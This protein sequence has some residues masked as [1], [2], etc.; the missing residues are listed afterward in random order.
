MAWDGIEQ[1]EVEYVAILVNNVL[2]G[3]SCTQTFLYF[4]HFRKNDK[5][6]IK[7]LVLWLWICDTTHLILTNRGFWVDIV[8]SDNGF[9]VSQEYL[10]ASFFTCLVALPCQLFFVYR[11]WIFAGK[12]WLI[13]MIFVPASVYQLAGYIAF[14]VMNYKTISIAQF[15]SLQKLLKSIWGV[16][17]VE[18]TL[19]TLV[20]F[21]ML[22][23]QR[24]G[25][26]LG[27]TSQLLYRVMFIGINT[28]TWTALVA[29]FALITMTVWPNSMAFVSLNLVISPIY[30][31]TLLANLNARDYIRGA[32]DSYGGTMTGT[33]THMTMTPSFRIT[34]Q[35]GM[36]TLEM[37]M[38]SQAGSNGATMF[39]Q[40]S[41]NLKLENEGVPKTRT[42]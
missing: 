10:W 8:L 35:D 22:W 27:Q 25:E 13:P 30:C 16:S 6:L 12:F 40:S 33:N 20:L 39:D 21:Y 36:E 24:D 31:N 4:L 5:N 32:R 9:I 42:M 23:K 3:I 26:L 19:I 41:A 37:D 17:A 18:D 28:G 34:Q 29:L 15:Y 1:A 7:A 14:L 38:E 11:I 2:W